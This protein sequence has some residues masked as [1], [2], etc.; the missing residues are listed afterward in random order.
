MPHF[1]PLRA[2]CG[3]EGAEEPALFE[4]S[5]RCSRGSWGLDGPAG[6]LGPPF[7]PQGR[8]GAR[9]S[10]F[11]GEIVPLRST[12]E[13]ARDQRPADPTLQQLERLS[14]FL[15]PDGTLTPGNTSTV[16]DGA[17]MVVVVSQPVWEGLGRPRAP[18]LVAS[19]A[20]GVPPAVGR[21]RRSRPCASSSAGSTG[22]R[23]KDIGTIELSRSSAARAIAFAADLGAE[24]DVL[25]PAG[26]AVVRSHPVGGSGR[27]SRGA[28]VLDHGAG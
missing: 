4:W 25:N 22:F 21:A 23:P 14:P 27:G 3:A 19:A 2:Q 26:G 12:T 5:W 6:R 15:S 10:P 9:G 17:A 13:E 18:R 24:E 20:P 11:I 7:A 28:S 8:G 16:R 1:L